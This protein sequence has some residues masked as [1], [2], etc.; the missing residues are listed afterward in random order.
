MNK[1]NQ[2]IEY[3]EAWHDEC[4]KWVAG[5]CNANGGKIYIGIDD[6]KE[7][8]TVE[9]LEQVNLFVFNFSLTEIV[10]INN[11]FDTL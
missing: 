8:A 3:K 4:L 5:F 6:N 2:N 1:E 9:G 7:E 10:K 11:F